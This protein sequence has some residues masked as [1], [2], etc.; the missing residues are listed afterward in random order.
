MPATITTTTTIAAPVN[1]QLI[2]RL[3]VR[4]K[5]RL[6]YGMGTNPS[7][8][9]R[10]GG[11]FTAKW[12]RYEHLAPSTTALSEQ[13]GTLT[14]PF[15]NSAAPS[16]TDVT[17]AVSKYGQYFLLNEEVDLVNVSQQSN[18][19]VDVL[20]ASAGRSINQIQRNEMEDNAT[21]VRAGGATADTAIVSKI[22]AKNLRSV[23]GTLQKNTAEK[24]RPMTL[25]STNVNT[26]PVRKAFWGICHVDV[27]MDIRDMAG[28]IPVESY[29]GQTEI[30]EEEFGT[31]GGVRWIC[32]EEASTSANGGGAVGSTGLI[33]TGGSN[34]DL[35][36]SVIY[37]MNAVGSLGL[38][39]SIIDEQFVA[40]E[41]PSP[42]ELIVKP[43]GS[44]GAGDPFNE[45]S[46][47]A[48]KFWMASKIL[49]GNW[50]R[51]LTSGATDQSS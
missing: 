35:Y 6:T 24:F 15:R 51:R 25:G 44:A 4:A 9:V 42:I 32:T 33:S 19:L 26:S 36:D 43:A 10:H 5:Q 28:F 16:V 22:T 3:L 27:E 37:G 14:L 20:G 18:E 11:S 12:R 7:T 40:G 45:I 46:T 23:V 48:Y 1:V 17:K 39:T 41:T 13:T 31:V 8:I 34:I 49:N 30:A 2:A 47:A 29:A 50:I 38:D 21:Q